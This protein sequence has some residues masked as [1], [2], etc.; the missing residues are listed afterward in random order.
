MPLQV[1]GQLGTVAKHELTKLAFDSGIWFLGFALV[2]LSRFGGE[3][4]SLVLSCWLRVAI[5]YR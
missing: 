2:T 1:L 3:S 5:G 4:G